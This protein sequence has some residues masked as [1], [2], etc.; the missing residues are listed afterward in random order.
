LNVIHNLP[1]RIFRTVLTQTLKT[2]EVIV[3]VKKMTTFAIT[4]IE[5]KKVS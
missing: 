1:P 5:I 2:F 4:S 3:K